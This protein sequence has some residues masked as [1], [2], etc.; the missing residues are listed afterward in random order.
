M[1]VTLQTSATQFAL[2]IDGRLF[3][4]P[5]ADAP[6]L[7]A[8][9][10]E[11]AAKLA[12]A[13]SQRAHTAPN[14]EAERPADWPNWTLSQGL[15]VLTRDGYLTDPAVIRS[16]GRFARGAGRRTPFAWLVGLGDTWCWDPFRAA[17][18]R[19][20]ARRIGI[21]RD[22]LLAFRAQH[23]SQVDTGQAP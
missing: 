19:L 1:E 14:H 13:G 20:S 9:L 21:L 18:P 15:T 17:L 5:P 22:A 3:T 4:C 6:A 8:A 12:A 7:A 10:Q 2:T 11:A 16:V 23:P